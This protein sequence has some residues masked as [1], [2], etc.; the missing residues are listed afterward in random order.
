M[1]SDFFFHVFALERA[2]E[3]VYRKLTARIRRPSSP[4]S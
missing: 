4:L 1:S 2:P 3:S